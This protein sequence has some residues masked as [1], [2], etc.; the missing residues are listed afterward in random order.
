MTEP[1]DQPL[2]FLPS[3]SIAE[4]EGRAFVAVIRTSEELQ[5]WLREPSPDVQWLQVERLLVDADA[6]VAAAGG[7][8][9]V[10]L[11]VVL[12]DPGAEFANLYRL[13][14]VLGAREVRVTMPATQGFLKALRLAASLRI[15]VRLLPSQPSREALDELAGAIS[16]YLHDPMVET[17]VEPFHSLLAAMRNS[18]FGSLWMILEEDPAVFVRYGHDGQLRLPRSVEPKADEGALEGFVER[19]LAGLVAEGAECVTCPWQQTC[20][21]Y[22]KWPDR[23]YS[24]AGVKQLFATIATAAEE[25]GQ[26]LA[27]LPASMR[28][29]ATE[30]MQPATAEAVGPIATEGEPL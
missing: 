21:G 5:H 24:C 15:P 6:C 22:F 29:A 20:A 27:A 23:T 1:S 9:D 25:I 18:G 4:H 11:D 14:D 10:P 8:S 3:E 26:E 13:V 16:F 12:S 17:P 2:V 30:V 7:G 19:H 28:L